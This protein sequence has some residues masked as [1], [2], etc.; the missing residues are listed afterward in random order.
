MPPSLSSILTIRASPNPSVPATAARPHSPDD[1]NP[2]SAFT[3]DSYRTAHSSIAPSSAAATEGGSTVRGRPSTL[4]H[5]FTLLKPG[6]KRNG[7]TASPPQRPLSTDAAW[8][9]FELIFSSGLLTAK[10]D[11]CNKRL[12]W[13]PVLECDDCGLRYYLLY[14]LLK[15]A[16]I[17]T[18]EPTSNVE[19]WLREIAVCTHP[20]MPPTMP[21]TL[22][23]PSQR[24]PRPNDSPSQIS[25]VHSTVHDDPRPFSYFLYSS[26]LHGL[27]ALP[28]ILLLLIINTLQVQCNIHDEILLGLI[29]IV[30]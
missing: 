12:G 25:C 29:T 8:N 7:G 13:K 27:Q 15:S 6:A 5:R 24:N 11:I 26:H 17:S 4:V 22:F 16:L 2:E 28:T 20:V 9:P 30:V 19:N 1:Y 21:F 3:I 14:L 23:L 18:Q 10:C